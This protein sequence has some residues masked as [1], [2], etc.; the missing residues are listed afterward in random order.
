MIYCLIFFFKLLNTINDDFTI[1]WIKKYN[2][3]S[4][5]EDGISYDIKQTSD[6]GFIITGTTDKYRGN[7]FILKTDK[8][9]NQEW[10]KYYGMKKWS[11]SYS[12]EQT[13]DNG[14]IICGNNGPDSSERK[15]LWIIKLDPQG[16]VIWEK[17]LGGTGYDVAYS[18]KQTFD[19]GFIICGYTDSKGNGNKDIW[20]IKLDSQGNVA[21]DNVYGTVNDD[22]SHKIIE[23][24]DGGYAF[25]GILN[26]YDDFIQ[27]YG[28]YTVIKL[29]DIGEIQWQKTYNFDKNYGLAKSIIQTDDGGF[30]V[31]GDISN[32]VDTDWKIIKIN[33]KGD[34]L[35]EKKYSGFRESIIGTN[36]TLDHSEWIIKTNN[37]KYLICGSKGDEFCIIEL[38]SNGEISFEKSFGH[39]RNQKPISLTQTFDGGYAIC[40]RGLDNT[41]NITLIKIENKDFT[42]KKN[43]LMKQMND[44]ISKISSFFKPKGEFENESEYYER[45]KKGEEEKKSIIESFSMRIEKSYENFVNEFQNNILNKNQEIDYQIRL[46]IEETALKIEELGKYNAEKETFPI[47]IDGFTENVFIPRAEAR[48]FKENYL[49]ANVKGYKRLFRDLKTYEYYNLKIVHPITGNTYCFGKQ[50]SLYN[51]FERSLVTISTEVG[52]IREKPSTNSTIIKKTSKGESF[53]VINFTYPWFYIKINDEIN[54]FIHQSIC[55]ETQIQVTDIALEPPLLSLSAELIEPSGNGFLDGEEKGKIIV[56][57]NNSGK[58]S[59]FGVIVDIN[60]KTENPSL[61]YSRTRVPGEI[62]PGETKEIDF[63]IEA[64]ECISRITH[65]FTI[66]ALESNGFSSEPIILKFETHPILLPEISMIDY[67]VTTA[68]GDSEIIPGET[69]Y[70]KLRF[71]NI[72]QGIAENVN[73]KLNLP[74]NVYFN[75]ESMKEYSITSLTSGE[76]KD[77]E[78]SILTSNEV[79]EQIELVIS[80]NEKHISKKYSLILE[81]NKPLKSI[82]EFVQKGIEETTKLIVIA[83][84]LTTDIAKNIPKSRH[85]N[86]D[87]IAVVIG[88]RNYLKAKNVEFAINDAFLMK[89]YLTKSFGIKEG[90]IFFLKNASK[91][92]LELYFGTKDNFKGKLYNTVKENESDIYIYYSGHGAPSLKDKRG[93]FVPIECD[94]NYVELSGY[95]L[96]TFY[97]NLAKI[98]AKSQTIILDACFSGADIFDNISPIITKT[99][100]PIISLD[101]S[102]VFSSSKDSEVS[103]WYNEK[104]HGM[105]TYFFLKAI[106]DKNAD[107]DNNDQLTA[108]E[109]ITYILNNSEGVPYYARKIHGLDQNPQLFGKNKKRV[110]I[111]YE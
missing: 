53:T 23:T 84:D 37:D 12:V 88:N 86:S 110:I 69:V 60:N 64:D 56:R 58:G 71:Q 92:D 105:F 73:F 27:A 76:Y 47:T 1:E 43:I 77:I 14:Y 55:S 83:S 49:N 57:I 67:G 85:V 80:M 111:Y 31:C 8:D 89:E 109:I 7:S 35:W 48:S 91:G 46:S 36:S 95:S 90:N 94:P 106:H 28:K 75:P 4:K 63:N 79:N 62:A 30:A 87:A 26:E 66:S 41:E 52:N 6:Q 104:Q 20:I 40:G 74:N 5:Y 32:L 22:Y 59:A 38:D 99:D 93:Y 51:I 98:P 102:I 108:K 34:L 68:S 50:K 100:N 24:L 21:W 15:D 82:Q 3:F 29:N 33:Y 45:I 18:I 81:I 44:E 42:Q 65:S 17:S 13:Y 10:T 107:S 19:H 103:S 9:G 16:N 25:C 2:D 54:G 96:Q 70:I 97:D 78:F 11:C 72:E 61:T 101:N 39:S